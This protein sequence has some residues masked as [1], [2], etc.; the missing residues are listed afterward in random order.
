MKKMKYIA[1]HI[2]ETEIDLEGFLCTSIVK[3]TLK[4]EVDEYVNIDETPLVM[5]GY[6]Y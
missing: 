3:A 2:T 4:V 5:D 1:P 6:D